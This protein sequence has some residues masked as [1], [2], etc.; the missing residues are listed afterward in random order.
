[1]NK[2]S[3]L[4][5]EQMLKVCEIINPDTE[6][7][8]LQILDNDG[9]GTDDCYEFT[10]TDESIV[11]FNIHQSEDDEMRYYP[12]GD[13]DCEFYSE[14]NNPDYVEFKKITEFLNSV[15]KPSKSSNTKSNTKSITNE[16]AEISD[17]DIKLKFVEIKGIDKFTKVEDYGSKTV[18]LDQTILDNLADAQAGV[19]DFNLSLENITGKLQRSNFN[20]YLNLTYRKKSDQDIFILDITLSQI[21]L[22]GYDFKVN[23]LKDGKITFLFDDNETITVNK[24]ISYQEGTSE[25]LYLETDI[26]FLSNIINSKNIE[27]RLEGTRGVIS[28]SKFSTSDVFNFIGFYNALFDQ[29]FKLDEIV[30]FMNKEIIENERKKKQAKNKKIEEHKKKMEATIKTKNKT[31]TTSNKSSSSCFVVTAT[32]NDANHPVVNDFRTYRDKYLATNKL[33]NIF[34][35]FYYLIGP[36]FADLINNHPSLRKIS[37]SYFIK[38]IHS[39]IHKKNDSYKN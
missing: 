19:S 8:F 38:P 23:A 16:K 13:I 33:G 39:L 27:Y 37:Y 2:Y 26:S 22:G 9:K 24:V 3:K 25:K 28:E 11:Q 35:K 1:M 29:T 36:H 31:S 10:A 5:K 18:R 6:W 15:N 12:L 7:S 30:S 20:L 4:S 34:I 21:N 17:N 32:M 14:I